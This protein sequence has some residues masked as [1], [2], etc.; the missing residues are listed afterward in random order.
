MLQV[1][2]VKALVLGA[3]GPI[4]LALSAHLPL[5]PLAG[6][7]AAVRK[8]VPALPLHLVVP[9]L[10][11]VLSHA[12]LPD[13]AAMLGTLKEVPVVPGAVGPDLEALAGLQVLRPLALVGAA[14]GMDVLSI[15]ICQVVVPLP[16]VKVSLQ[17]RVRKPLH[18]SVPGHVP[19]DPLAGEEAAVRKLVGPL[20]LHEV[21]LEVALVHVAGGRPPDA[22]TVLAATRELPLVP[23]AVRLRLYALAV[24]LAPS[25]LA[26]IAGAIRVYVLP[27]AVGDVLGPLAL[28]EVALGRREAPVAVLLEAPPLALVL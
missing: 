1:L 26:V 24:L 18:L 27:L 6:V 15:A 17:L 4:H 8:D 3:V 23:A 7:E 9:E 21:L 28:V 12:R 19:L 10:A 5:L 2:L 13:A 14:V 20:S 11:P 16:L 25:P 22:L